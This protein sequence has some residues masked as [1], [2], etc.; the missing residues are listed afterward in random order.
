MLL[1]GLM[2]CCVIGRNT[3]QPTRLDWYNF[4]NRLEEIKIMSIAGARKQGGESIG[5]PYLHQVGPNFRGPD[6]RT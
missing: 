3:D 6:E 1:V 4:K 5:E 2:C